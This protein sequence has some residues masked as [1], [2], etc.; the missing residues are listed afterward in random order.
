MQRTKKPNR[1]PDA[2]NQSVTSEFTQVPNDLLRDPSL[3]F[4]A[5]GMLCLLLSNKEGWYS[6]INT[7]KQ[8]TLEGE[9]AIRSGISE[10]EEAG[11]LV[12]IQYRDKQTK[13]RRGSFWA[14]TDIPGYFKFEKTLKMLDSRGMEPVPGQENVPDFPDMENP[15]M[16]SPNLENPGLKILNNKNTNDKKNEDPAVADAITLSQFDQ[17]W[18]IYPKKDGK[19]AAWTAWKKLCNKSP[20]N[21]PTWSTIEIA[22]REQNKS[23]RWQNKKFIPHASTW[24][25]QERWLDDPAEMV[26][27]DKDKD[28]PDK[29]PQP[30]ADPEQILT[31]Y[32]SHTNRRPHLFIDQCFNRA[33][34]LINSPNNGS[35]PALAENMG[36][37]YQWIEKKQS[38]QKTNDHCYDPMSVVIY[39][40][41]WIEDNDWIKDRDPSL[42]RHSSKLFSK[43]LKH[44]AQHN[45]D[46]DP[47][48]GKIV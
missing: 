11:Y 31:Q 4:K 42:F 15:N 13:I 5:K 12:R 3:S 40:L 9:D 41:N 21:R 35:L 33:K 46:R 25:N 37:L 45:F 16:D 10:L 44:E 32:V 24:L 27:Y 39:Y 18:Q 6:Y 48:T 19:G 20:K 22:I 2:I 43:F 30:N 14:Y 7:I 8:M 17:F 29:Q 26:S 38:S 23:E 34:E 47:I 1:M 36:E 28:N